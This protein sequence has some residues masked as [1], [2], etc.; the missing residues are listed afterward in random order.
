MPERVH[1]LRCTLW[2]IFK[3][4][5]VQF[6]TLKNVFGT[7]LQYVLDGDTFN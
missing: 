2:N 3:H 7:L 4:Y 1:V 5:F 6:E